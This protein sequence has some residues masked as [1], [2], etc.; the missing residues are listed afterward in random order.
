MNAPPYPDS[1]PAWR[2]LF[3]NRTLNLR[4]I[5]AIGYDMD[6]TLIHYNVAEW[7]AR[8]FYYLREKL[9]ERGWEVADLEFEP[10]FVIRGVIIDRAHGNLIK[11]NRFGYVKAALHGT[12]RLDFDAHRK[13]YSREVVD[14]EDRRYA[15]LNTFFS[16]SEACMYAHLVD[17]LDA[18]QL[19]GV[20]G[21]AELYDTVRSSLDEAHME[22]R[23]KA[24]IVADPDL[25]VEVDPE[26]L[27]TLEDQR[28]SGK[29]LLLITNS[30]Y[31]YTHAMMSYAFDRHLPDGSTWRD[32]FDFIVV[33]STKPAFFTDTNP[34]FEVATDTGMLRPMSGRMEPGRVYWGASAEAVERAL[35]VDGSEIL[36]VGDHVFGDVHV[37]KGIRR[38]RTALIVRELEGE[39]RAL[40]AFRAE[41]DELTAMMDRKMHMEHAFSVARIHRQRLGRKYGPQPEA[42][43]EELDA[44]IGA[45]RAQLVELDAK[46][47]PLASASAQL[48]NRRWGLLMRTGND[49]SH[50]AYQIERHADVYTSRVS[51]FL[52]ATP[53]VYLRSSRG[54]LPHDTGTP[55]NPFESD[56]R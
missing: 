20:L 43:A 9:T 10:D 38:W 33:E 51:N 6:Y 44:R 18:G 55:L 42:T 14:L 21:Y 24:E 29:K 27:L 41:Q 13:L 45:L 48:N 1:I 53:F 37:S 22:G 7:E 11:V 19:P 15:F 35:G 50:M 52:Y 34:T 31:D 17:R 39:L 46:I 2:R 32:L 54:S 49:K 36:Y 4:A 25:F 40:E 23:L 30:G 3:C 16:V 56:G 5:K 8:A 12:Q 28:A 47:A 26:L